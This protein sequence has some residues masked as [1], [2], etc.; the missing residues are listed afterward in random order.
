MIRQIFLVCI[1]LLIAGTVRAQVA[2]PDGNQCVK[3]S[4]LEKCADVADQL[5]AARVALTKLESE[6]SLTQA[7]REAA[8]SLIKGLNDYLAVKDRIIADYEQISKMKDGVI[9]LYQQMV[10]KL[11][12]QVNRPK[13]AW[14]KFL[15]VL[16]EIALV[17]AGITVGRGL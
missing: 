13:S 3:Q 5:A 1:L 9:A 6:R 11:V 2:C 15:Q 8:Q 14:Q 17:A 16:K 4:V 10:E 7:E 12:A